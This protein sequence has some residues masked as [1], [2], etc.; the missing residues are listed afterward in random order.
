VKI[1]DFGIARMMR[2]PAAEESTGNAP[3]GAAPGLTAEA[4]LGT[5]KYMAP[6][7]AENS[8]EADHRADIYSLGVVFYEMLTGELPG[9]NLEP[10]SRKV[11]IDVRLDEIVLRALERKP[12]LRYQQASE[13]K[14]CVETIVSSTSGGAAPDSAP[15]QSAINQ[16]KWRNP[17][18]HSF[19]FYFSKRYSRVVV[20]CL[21]GAACLLGIILLVSFSGVWTNLRFHR[22]QQAVQNPDAGIP[23][24]AIAAYK[25]D[26]PFRI[27]SLGTVDSSNTVVFTIAQDYVQAVVKRVDARERLPVEAEDRAGKFFGYGFLRGVDNQMDTTTGTLKCSATI[28]PDGDH[29]MLR[30]MF[31]NIYLTV[32]VK[33]G[34]TLAPMQAVQHDPEGAFVWAIKPDQTVTHQVVQT[35]TADGATVEIQKGLSP[36]NLVVTGPFNNLH[37][38][39]KVHYKLAQVDVKRPTSSHPD[40]VAAGQITSKALDWLQIQPLEGWFSDLQS[41]DP[42]VQKLAQR[43]LTEMGTN[44]LPWIL[45][46]LSESTEQSGEGDA[47]RLNAAQAVRFAG[48][49]V[50]SEMPAFAA[51]LKSG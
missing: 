24:Q 45:K 20:G 17:D 4:I 35:G 1:A 18:N 33:H 38:G 9:K 19:L 40:E 47:R 31:L 48:P 13:V 22:P 46:F 11:H 14:T 39:R 30:G 32:E 6:E 26:I 10:P 27:A 41:S 25:G 12:E 29:L 28:V 50:K 7:Q 34:V 44:S 49:G 16:T 23:V 21:R 5:P 42:K 43:A 15:N 8:R 37:E 2:E 36:G 51:L 3:E